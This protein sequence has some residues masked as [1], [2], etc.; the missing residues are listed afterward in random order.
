MTEKNLHEAEPQNSSSRMARYHTEKAPIMKKEPDEK[1]VAA[2]T[3]PK[4]QATAQE[5]MVQS[6]A[7]L[8][9]GNIFSRLLGA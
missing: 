5:K 9:V 7:W 2:T 6:T 1:V 4:K 3:A 8:T